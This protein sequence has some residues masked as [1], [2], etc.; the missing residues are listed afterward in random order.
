M[1]RTEAVVIGKL[2]G[3][4]EVRFSANDTVRTFAPTA[5]FRHLIMSA[6]AEALR[7]SLQQLEELLEE[8]SPMMSDS[9]EKAVDRAIKYGAVFAEVVCP[10]HTERA[11]N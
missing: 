7:L 5:H 1:R 3:Y 9:T 2:S 6:Q 10:I 4:L 8:Y 11:I